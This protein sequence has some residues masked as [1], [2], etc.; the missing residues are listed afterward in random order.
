MAKIFISY[1]QKD[2]EIVQKIA[3]QLKKNGHS[4]FFAEGSIQPGEKFQETI[5]KELKEAEVIVFVLSV[6]SASSNWVSTEIGMALGYWQQRGKPLIIPVIIDEVKIPPQ[7]LS[8]QSLFA[9]NKSTSEIAEEVANIV[10]KWQGRMKAKEHQREEVQERVEQNA[11]TYIKNSLEE[12]KM[13]EKNFKNWAYFWY[14]LAYL[15]LLAALIFAIIKVVALDFDEATWLLVT[16]LLVINIIIVGILAAL[17][18]YAFILGKSFMVESLRNSDRIHAISFG[19][20]YLKAFGAQ[21]EWN[22]IKEAF[23]HW[24]I[25][26]GST[27]IDQNVK[28]IDPELLKVIVEVAKQFTSRLKS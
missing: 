11:A 25:D 13:K 20:F 2:T 17:S 24:N 18:R 1:S 4:P 28:D 8:I 10:D 5:F 26:K 14:G 19:E 22:E 3:T 12:L 15:A 23:Q 7:L 9:Q 27:F 21:S 16:Q 6:N